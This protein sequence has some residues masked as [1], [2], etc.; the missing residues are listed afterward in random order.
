MEQTSGGQEHVRTG[1]AN[2]PIV[3]VK[4][5][6]HGVLASGE[7]K[8]CDAPFPALLALVHAAPTSHL[9]FADCK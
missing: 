9:V 8:W 2:L 7:V 5:G 6:L 3:I 4:R 1:H